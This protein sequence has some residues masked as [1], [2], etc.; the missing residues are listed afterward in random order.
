MPFRLTRQRSRLLSVP[1]VWVRVSAMTDYNGTNDNNLTLIKIT[2][3]FSTY[4][5]FPIA[6]AYFVIINLYGKRPKYPASLLSMAQRISVL[7]A[8]FGFMEFI[9]FFII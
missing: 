2:F 7:I 5:M 4:A 1:I 6:V 9:N 3:S 8:R